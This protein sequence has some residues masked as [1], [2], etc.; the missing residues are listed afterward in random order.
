MKKRMKREPKE[1]EQTSEDS[2][3]PEQSRNAPPPP[4]VEVD[5][6]FCDGYVIEDDEFVS[7]RIKEMKEAIDRMNT[8][9]G[10]AYRLALIKA[11]E[12]CGD[13]FHLMCL[14]SEYFHPIVSVMS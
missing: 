8:D 6:R 5:S 4:H 3:P 14:R 2:F 10:L 11:P 9:T 12:Q 13:A 7:L 1:E